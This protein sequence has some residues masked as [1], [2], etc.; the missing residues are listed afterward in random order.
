MGFWILLLLA[1][2][3][4]VIVS[5]FAMWSRTNRLRE[6]IE[7][8]R[9]R[10]DYISARAGRQAAAE[11]AQEDIARSITPTSD[12][13][14]T[15][16]PS[17][18][19]TPAPTAP[20]APDTSREER[21]RAYQ[22]ALAREAAAL[23]ETEVL[24]EKP[25][26]KG[27]ASSSGFEFQF[28]QKLPVWIGGV[29]IAL[30]GFYLF[31][32]AIDE[33]LLTE[34]VR[35]TMGA[36]L[37]VALIGGARFIR[38][39]RPDMADGKR[40]AQALAGS[41][42][43]VLY[44]TV[45]AATSLYHFLPSSMGLVFMAA[46]TFAAV[47]ISLLHGMPVAV[48]GMVGGFLT[49]AL[50][51]TGSGNGVALF[52]YLFV[53]VAGLFVLIRVRAWWALAVPVMLFA[54]GWVLVWVFLGGHFAASDGLFLG[55]FILAVCAAAFAADARAAP[56]PATAETPA[57][58]DDAAQRGLFKWLALGG[59]VLLMALITAR[60]DFGP[61]EWVLYGA[62]GLGTI[63]LAWFKPAEYGKAPAL[64]MGVNMLLLLG[65]RH[66]VDGTLLFTHLAFAALYALP[67][68][69]LF[70]RRPKLYWAG[71][72]SAAALGFYG[73]AYFA[74]HWQVYNLVNMEPGGTV[75]VWGALALG[76][77]LGF[78]GLVTKVFRGFEG[79]EALRDRLLALFTL[80][81]TAF[82]SISLLIEV[83]RDFLTVA[84]AAEMLATCWVASKIDIKALR[85]TAG[86]LFGVFLLCL[87]PQLLLL[88]G[89]A[90]NS[91][92]GVNMGKVMPPLASEPLFQLGLPMAMAGA[93]SWF[94]RLRADGK[95]VE[96]LEVAVVGLGALMLYYLARH[97]F[98]VPEDVVFRKAG[99]FERGIITNIFFGAAMLTVYGGRLYSRRALLWA[100]S[101]LFG[102]ALFRVVWFDFLFANPL[103]AYMQLVGNTPLFNALLLAYALPLLWLWL[104]EKPALR[105]ITLPAGIKGLLSFL[106]VFMLVT[107]NVRQLFHGENLTTGSTV[108]A[109]IYSYSA[110]WLLL[111]AGLLLAGTLKQ[112]KPLRIGSLVVMILTVAKV[113]LYDAGELTGLFRVFSFMGLGLSLLGL[114]WF[115]SRFVFKK[116][117]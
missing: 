28:G 91:L 65:W 7:D 59:G 30:S 71:L 62:L 38:L 109:E 37:G 13:I 81:T 45:Y 26:A 79:D 22:A 100:G 24:R 67:A 86:I 112:H 108:N 113:F 78:A 44:A 74:L 66:P 87:L 54:F 29:A 43:A 32:Y 12:T 116:E 111:G 39:K 35:V 75:H 11:A 9:R 84:F 52:S 70:L 58:D 5:C 34:G 90:A 93:S 23:R 96:A 77:A 31:K 8:I 33:G 19:A 101:L 36:L 1:F 88:F 99:F 80:V 107:T 95:L 98:K 17:P 40:I 57:A 16:A 76:I 20:P 50:I 117:G 14:E 49:P 27:K 48:L 18:V 110:A 61:A 56:L 63:V 69:A 105:I 85:K 53:I 83:H 106:F 55:L 103:F 72:L 82:L 64:A 115:Y 6:E 2:S 46:V 3:L 102:M 68:L 51:Q 73:I 4:F 10:L 25:A 89:L 104:E 97:V 60:C 114:S 47:L 92:F 21:N 15:P 41:G 42:I 94:L